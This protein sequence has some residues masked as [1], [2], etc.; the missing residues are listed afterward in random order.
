M[1]EEKNNRRKL[2]AGA[3]AAVAAAGTASAQTAPQ[4]KV[5]RA[6]PKPAK[7]PREPLRVARWALIDLR[8][9]RGMT[10]ADLGRLVG[11]TRTIIGQLER[12]TR[13]LVPP[14]DTDVARWLAMPDDMTA[15]ALY[16]VRERDPAPHYVRNTG[17]TRTVRAATGAEKFVA[18]LQSAPSPAETQENSAT[19][20]FATG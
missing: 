9:K 17:A 3:V 18:D 11:V 4:K 19:H 16:A 1:P 8:C 7:T 2:L 15:E 10:Q 14:M 5:H 12:G 20:I 13:E 6:G